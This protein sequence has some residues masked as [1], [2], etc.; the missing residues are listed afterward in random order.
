LEHESELTKPDNH[1]G[2]CHL[3]EHL[4]SEISAKPDLILN[5]QHINFGRYA[6]HTIN[7][8]GIDQ[9]NNMANESGLKYDK[10]SPIK[11]IDKFKNRSNDYEV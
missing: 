3:G 10:L 5:K 2:H 1:L 11:I 6:N 9:L 4:G 8:I 7:R